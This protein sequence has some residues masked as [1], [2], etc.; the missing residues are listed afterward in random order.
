MVSTKKVV[1]EYESNQ[2]GFEVSHTWYDVENIYPKPSTYTTLDQ[3]CKTTQQNVGQNDIGVLATNNIFYYEAS[4][5]N[6]FGC[7]L[8]GSTNSCKYSNSKFSCFYGQSLF[9]YNAEFDYVE[10][11][12]LTE[13]K[14]VDPGSGLKILRAYKV[15][16][17]DI[18]GINQGEDPFGYGIR[19][20][21]KIMRGA[22]A[23]EWLE[24]SI[25]HKD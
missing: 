25:E 19:A 20:D 18:D 7:I 13:C 1:C 16:C 15:F 6:Y 9:G 17:I 4:T 10:P 2:N 22:R 3:D 14:S 8:N 24:K 11:K 21:G 12:C 23:E 5:N